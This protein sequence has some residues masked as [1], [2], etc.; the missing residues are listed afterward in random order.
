MR[1]K[2]YIPGSEKGFK[3]WA[4]NFIDNLSSLGAEDLMPAA[5]YQE[6]VRL[7]DDYNKKY[8]IS[9]D[10]ETRTSSTVLARQEARKI[11]EK[12]IRFVVRTYLIYN[13]N[14]TNAQRELM[15]LPIHK[16]DRTPI[17]V[18]AESP[19]MKLK[20]M[21]AGQLAVE[22]KAQKAGDIEGKK[23]N[24]KPYGMDG[25]QIVYDVLPEPP[26]DHAKFT[27]QHLATRTPYR[28]Y[29]PAVERG[30]TAYFAIAWVNE[31]GEVGPFSQI[32]SEIIP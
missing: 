15:G 21:S 10:K 31:K 11:C 25:A 7:H 22:F 16:T 20:V 3:L 27:R 26:I 5:T 29:F 28:V 12:E 14:V 32:L 2:N 4:D 24:A 9:E 6:L 19:S 23:S 1:V 30:K 13:P 18:P 17:G 8:R